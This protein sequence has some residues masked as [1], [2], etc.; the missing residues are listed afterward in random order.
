MALK[1]GQS[2]RKKYP[3]YT[4]TGEKFVKEKRKGLL[5]FNFTGYVTPAEV[6]CVLVRCDLA[7]IRTF[8]LCLLTVVFPLADETAHAYLKMT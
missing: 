5:L 3:K 6:H 2:S 4:E 8:L 7:Y 1:S